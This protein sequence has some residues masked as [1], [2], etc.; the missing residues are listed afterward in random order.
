ML[1][2][3]RRRRV[4]LYSLVLQEHGYVVLLL[5]QELHE[6]HGLLLAGRRNHGW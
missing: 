5:R 2:H 3:L 1:V 6:E 4:Y